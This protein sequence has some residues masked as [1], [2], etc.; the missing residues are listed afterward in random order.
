MFI[1][2]ADSSQHQPLVGLLVASGWLSAIFRKS[3]TS[4]VAILQALEFIIICFNHSMCTILSV[5][6]HLEISFISVLSCQTTGYPNRKHSFWGVLGVQDSFVSKMLQEASSSFCVTCLHSLYNSFLSVI[7]K[8]TQENEMKTEIMW[9]VVIYFVGRLHL[10][11]LERCP[12][13]S[14]PGHT[15][16]QR[17]R[18]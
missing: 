10:I 9:T 15:L 4:L 3:K 16:F 11:L 1:F 12:T 17:C 5:E 7:S 6:S 8:W 13:Q 2:R 18:F 14:P